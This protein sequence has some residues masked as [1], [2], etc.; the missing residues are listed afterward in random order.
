M[1]FIRK[2]GGETIIFATAAAKVDGETETY[3]RPSH[4][5]IFSSVVNVLFL[6][7]SSYAIKSSETYHSINFFRIYLVFLL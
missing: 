7:N 5:T 3:C 2:V 6:F 4:L 1:K